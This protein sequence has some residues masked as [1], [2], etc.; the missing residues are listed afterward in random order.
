MA[1]PSARSCI[2]RLS[3][4]VLASLPCSSAEE[5]ACAALDLSGPDAADLALSCVAA[6]ALP[7]LPWF[8]G[9]G[10]VSVL[11]S[12]PLA[13]DAR[14]QPRPTAP[15]VH[16]LASELHGYFR[17]ASILLPPG[18]RGAS[19]S[20]LASLHIDDPVCVDVPAGSAA[21]RAY[22]R[23]MAA[24]PLRGLLLPSPPRAVLED[25]CAWTLRVP[26]TLLDAGDCAAT[27]SASVSCLIA[28]ARRSFADAA[29]VTAG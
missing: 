21:A 25:G 14:A 7:S 23:G 3:I 24:A 12:T 2:L 15:I 16:R 5:P 19:H 11:Q 10:H 9:R 28:G 22:S 8:E 17:N 4:A 1:C 20:P 26:S 27:S 18:D 13:D 6:H 29:E